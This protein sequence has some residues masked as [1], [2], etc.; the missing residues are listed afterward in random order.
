MALIL[1]LQTQL[2]DLFLVEFKGVTKVAKTSEITKHKYR[3]KYQ[4]RVI[5]NQ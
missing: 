5:K 2:Q 4:Y 1:Q 3:H